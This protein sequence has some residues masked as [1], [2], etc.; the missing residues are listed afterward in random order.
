MCPRNP[1]RIVIG[2]LRGGMSENENQNCHFILT[3]LHVYQYIVIGCNDDCV[4]GL[5][6]NVRL[7]SDKISS[8]GEWIAVAVLWMMMRR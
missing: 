8:C 7:I 2:A 3:T 6:I 5:P 1:F 4:N